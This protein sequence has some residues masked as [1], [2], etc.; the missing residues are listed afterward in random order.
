MG[1]NKGF[2]TAAGSFSSVNDDGLAASPTFNAI[3]LHVTKRD[4]RRQYFP[5]GTPL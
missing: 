4:Q 5:K 3:S 2:N 1:S